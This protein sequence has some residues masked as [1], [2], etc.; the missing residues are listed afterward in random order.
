MLYRKRKK[1]K[2][3]YKHKHS[4]TTVVKPPPRQHSAHPSSSST[5]RLCSRRLA[6]FKPRSS[7][8]SAARMTPAGTPETASSRFS[9]CHVASLFIASLNP[10]HM[11]A[12]R[13]TRYGTAAQLPEHALRPLHAIR[14]AVPSPA[15]PITRHHSAKT[16]SAP[17]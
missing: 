6:P 10:S 13:H 11:D 2:Q 3:N 4:P 14:T 15:T 12:A 17:A 8:S 7:F 16:P 5:R 9:T 1:G